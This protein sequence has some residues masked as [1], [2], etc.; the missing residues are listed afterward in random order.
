MGNRVQFYIHVNYDYC[1]GKLCDANL[2]DILA[3]ISSCV[4]NLNVMLNY[5]MEL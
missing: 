5:G 3:N 4:I 2:K 1:P